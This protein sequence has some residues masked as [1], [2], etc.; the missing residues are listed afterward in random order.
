MRL[1]EDHQQAIEEKDTTIA[2]LNDD[3][4]NREHDNV[5][6]QA[7]S[8]VYK[9]QLQKCQDIISRLRTG[10]APHTKDPGE[11]NIVMIIEKNT[12]P[13]EDEFYEHPYYIA[14]IQQRFIG[15]KI[16]WFKGQ[17]LHHRFIMEER[18]NGNGIHAFN[19][20]EEKGYV[21]H[22]QCHFRLVDIPFML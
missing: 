16:R 14:R 20:L 15:T 21:E 10:Y 7:P 2:L 9:E 18:D 11:D 17:Y 22:F 3:L 4:K 12:T 1:N 13:K 5:A 19:R 8:D 6:L